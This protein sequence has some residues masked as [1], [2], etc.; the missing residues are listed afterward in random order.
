MALRLDTISSDG[1]FFIQEA[2]EIESGTRTQAREKYDLNI[3]PLVLARLHQAGWDWET[4]AETWGVLCASLTVLPLYG[5]VRRQFNHRLA[6]LSCILYAFHPKL[7]EWSPEVL[8]ESTFWLLFTTSLYLIW[9]ANSEGRFLWYLLAGIST[10]LAIH[11]RF[12]GWFLTIPAA[13]WA[14]A[15]WFSTAQPR[16]RLASGMSLLVLG[17]PLT[18]MALTQ[19]FGYERWEWGAFHRVEM[20]I[21]WMFPDVEDQEVEDRPAT[22]PAD[23]VAASTSPPPTEDVAAGESPGTSSTAPASEPVTLA[24][25]PPEENSIPSKPAQSMTVG[26][27]AST[28]LKAATRGFNLVFLVLL[29]I[30]VI[31][32]SRRWLRMDY[33]PLV[34]VAV[35]TIA[36]IT[37][38]VWG[39]HLASSR[40]VLSLVIIST[41]IA[42]TG[43]LAFCTWLAE[44]VRR[45]DGFIQAKAARETSRRA[46][47]LALVCFGLFGTIDAV[48][49]SDQGREAKAVMGHWIRGEFGTGAR[50]AGS[51]T[52]TLSAYYADAQYQTLPDCPYGP[53]HP[54]LKT[55]AQTMDAVVVMVS[56]RWES[57]REFIAYAKEAGYEEVPATKLPRLCRGKLIVLARSHSNLVQA[58]SVMRN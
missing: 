39:A 13:G 24:A 18:M 42:S 5:W 45:G 2:R 46:L 51:W 14:L 33:L 35:V 22:H 58:N 11:T 4:A 30:G 50:V 37:V 19:A 32:S 53:N 28:V 29:G 27:T 1:A 21:R 6:L 49:S 31:A 17:Y 15:R 56:P 9:R 43:L 25:V 52:W 41:P 7:I 48:T 8:R 38:H 3:Y 10:T 12:E 26:K 44:G 20:A 23:A 36:A 47:R 40:Y 16:W 34:L 57:Q 55:M 54:D